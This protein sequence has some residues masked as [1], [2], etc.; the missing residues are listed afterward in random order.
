[1]ASFLLDWRGRL[2]KWVVF[3]DG[4]RSVDIHLPAGIP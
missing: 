2:G 1:M 3:L 4:G